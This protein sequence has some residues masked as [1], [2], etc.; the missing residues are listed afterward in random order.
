MCSEDN[1]KDGTIKGWNRLRKD[2]VM[3]VENASYEEYL[4]AMEEWKEKLQ[5]MQAAQAGSDGSESD[6]YVPG[7]RAED[8]P[9][10]SFNYDST[11]MMA[12]ERPPMPP[13][14]PMEETA[15][16]ST[17]S[18]ERETSSGEEALLAQLSQ[19]FRANEDSILATMEELGLSLED[20]QDE[21]NL[22]TLA[23]A[24]NEGAAER[25]LPTV[26][27]LDSLVSWLHETLS[28]NWENYFSI[29]E[30]A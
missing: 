7:I 17:E 13:M 26:D 5:Q 22:S 10:P 14:P 1:A 12:G 4:V 3:K 30:E 8:M 9:M 11:G 18:G 16:I 29:E 24:M 23:A 6:S 19:A 20:L 15:E 2:Y 21:E 25:G 27:D 28:E